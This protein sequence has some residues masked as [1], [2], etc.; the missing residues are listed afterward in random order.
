M[1]SGELKRLKGSLPFQSATFLRD[2]PYGA[3]SGV[4]NYCADQNAGVLFPCTTVVE[5]SLRLIVLHRSRFVAF[6]CVCVF[7]CVKRM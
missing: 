1:T 2:I 4:S 5:H 7:V 6:V 3:D